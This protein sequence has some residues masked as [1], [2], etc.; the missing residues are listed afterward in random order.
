MAEQQNQTTPAQPVE[1]VE[2]ND[3]FVTRFA[4]KHPRTA[5]VV[6]I[7][8]G[9]T[10]AGGVLLTANTVRKNSHHLDAAADNAK[11]ALDHVSSAVSPTDTEA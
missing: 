4:N 11:V 2:K 9:V 8:G 10:A 5:K 1:V 6:A 7:V 3:N